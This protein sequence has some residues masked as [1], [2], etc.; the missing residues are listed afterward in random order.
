MAQI[1]SGRSQVF[2]AG[3]ASSQKIVGRASSKN[4]VARYAFTTDAVGASSI[5]W[6]V[7]LNSLAGGSQTAGLSWAISADANNYANANAANGYVPN[8][9]VTIASDGTGYLTFSGSA[10]VILLPN[11]TYYLWIY[12]TTTTY[13]YFYLTSNEVATLTTSG[14]AGLVSILSGSSWNDH[15][16]YIYDGA[17][18]ALYLPYIYTGSGWELY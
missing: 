10:N 5:S 12:P 14:G 16:V 13:G 18:W 2:E 11:T 7:R 17:G 6:A 1:T 15:L 8:G 9:S 3:S 4:W